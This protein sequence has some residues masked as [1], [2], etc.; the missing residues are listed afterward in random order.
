MQA[1]GQ[2]I[3]SIAIL[4]ALPPNAA[5]ARNTFLAQAYAE[6]GR[7]AEAADTLL[8]ITA[9]M[10]RQEVEE[11]ARLLRSAPTK[12]DAP[13]SLPVFELGLNFVY[14]YVGALPRVMEAPERSL[15]IGYNI[16]ASPLWARVEAP[17]R[18]MERF[19]TF[20]RNAGLVDYWRTRG[21][22]DLCR[23]VGASDFACE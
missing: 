10:S 17:V 22:P 12:V 19:K 8:L 18:K 4:K 6:E 7:F 20:A 21:W 1:S 15:E 16:G 2:N 23:P 9:G 14:A 5:P 13:A 3:A 11:A